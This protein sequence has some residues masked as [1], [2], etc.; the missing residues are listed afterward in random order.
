MLM[1]QTADGKIAKSKDHFANWTS[2]EDKKHF[3]NFTKSH[4]VI[5]MGES[6]FNT[7]KKPLPGRLNLILSK[8][9]EKY[10]NLQKLGTLEFVNLRPKQV[11]DYLVNKG[12]K[13]AILGGGSYTNASFLNAGLVDEIILTT[14]GIL[15]GQGFGMC[16]GLKNDIKLN[17]LDAEILSNKTYLTHWEVL[18]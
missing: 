2:K 9:P 16:E 5:I 18:K 8:N 17:L 11:V 14:E 13:S 1:A 3:I 7:I 6:T 10:S 15:F 12:F 4:K